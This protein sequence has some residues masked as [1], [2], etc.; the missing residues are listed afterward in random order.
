MS[1]SAYAD[2]VITGFHTLVY[3]DDADAARAFFR[4][5][6]EW[7]R[8]DSGGGWLIFK[9]PP[10]EMGVHPTSNE[11]GAPA[12][13]TAEHHEI[14]LMCDDVRA[15]VAELKAKGVDFT[16]EVADRGFGLVA[17]FRV[18]GAGEMTLFQAA[19]PP[20]HQL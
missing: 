10:S 1:A 13:S 6:L 8:V 9:T 15:T 3:A 14:S 7:P 11:P 5:V 20:A 19:Y 17:T 4:D 16:S 2:R 12:W 18:P